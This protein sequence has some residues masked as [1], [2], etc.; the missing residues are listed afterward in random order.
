VLAAPASSG[1][2]GSTFLNGAEKF[3]GDE[4]VMAGWVGADIPRIR[5][6]IQDT[7]N[8]PQFQGV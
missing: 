3:M 2:S 6:N 5:R 8:S 1:D 7:G 4:R